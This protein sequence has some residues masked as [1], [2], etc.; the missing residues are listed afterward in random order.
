[1]GAKRV[2]QVYAC[3][4]HLHDRPFR[5][6]V[7]M[8]L[9]VKDATEKP[10]YWG[11]RDAMADMLGAT[12]S[13]AARHQAVKRA[14]AQLVEAGAI[15]LSYHG[16]VGKRSEYELTLDRTP[17][18][19]D[20]NRT[21]STVDDGNERGTVSDPERGTASE[22]KGVRPVNERGTATVP[23]RSTRSTEEHSE[24]EKSPRKVTNSAAPVTT[25]KSDERDRRLKL[26]RDRLDRE[27]SA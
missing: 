8:A 16:H 7:H 24:E 20:E 18:K 14:L 26:I 1:M 17:G 25:G 9:T 6:L 5:L 13:R 27:A 15:R 2:A 21:P 4:P 11:G 3:W 19:G 12:G 22:H 10:T 23:P